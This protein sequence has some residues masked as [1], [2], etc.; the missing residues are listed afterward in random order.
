MKSEQFALMLVDH[1]IDTIENK[2]TINLGQLTQI[3]S[4]VK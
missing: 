1:C 3:I 2:D 4:A